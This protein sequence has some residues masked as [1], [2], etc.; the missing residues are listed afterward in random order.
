[1]LLQDIN[2]LKLTGRIEERKK[3]P[4]EKSVAETGFPESGERVRNG[5]RSKTDLVQGQ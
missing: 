2:Q 5:C 1:M 3:R 4:S